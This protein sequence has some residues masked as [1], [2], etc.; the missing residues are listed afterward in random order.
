M[1]V[2]ARSRVAPS[3]APDDAGPV[4]GVVSSYA[5]KAGWSGVVFAVL[6]ALAMVLLSRVPGLAASDADYTAFY[7]DG[8]G[9]TLITVGLYLVP[10][11]G[12]ACLWHMIAT[13]TL[14]QVQRPTSWAEIPHWLH[15]AASVIFVCMLFA[16][17]AAA[18]AVALLTK[19]SDAPLP[20]PDVARALSAVGYTLVFVYGVRAAGMYIITTTGLARTAGVLPGPLVLLSYLVA[21]FLLVSTTFHP[22]ILLV[23][24]AWVLVVSIVLL[25]RRPTGAAS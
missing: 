11:A 15:L 12:I 9:G 24:P 21:V 14:L 10:F 22:A 23:F 6:L 19:F 25:V 18:G 20:G 2:P 7:R 4:P 1:R 13:R 17:S 3:P 8:G 16:G 5:R